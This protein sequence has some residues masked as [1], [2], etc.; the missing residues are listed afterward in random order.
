MNGRMDGMGGRNPSQED[1]NILKQKYTSLAL[2]R[3]C[4]ACEGDKHTL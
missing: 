1:L 3:E 2:C 4:S